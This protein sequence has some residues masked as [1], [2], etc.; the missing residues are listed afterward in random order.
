[1]SI[2]EDHAQATII[3]SQEVDEAALNV[4]TSPWGN[5]PNYGVSVLF[6]DWVEN[7]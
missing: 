3:T 1:M 6:T 7:T 4:H 2:I 5:K